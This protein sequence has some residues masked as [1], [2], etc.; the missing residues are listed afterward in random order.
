[1]KLN[2]TTIPTP[3]TAKISFFKVFESL[4]KLANDQDADLADYANKLLK[5]CENY[6]LLR[7]GFD[8]KKLLKKYKEPIGKILKLLFPDVLLTNEIKA[9]TAPFD[10]EPFYFSTRFDNIVKA[11]GKDFKFELTQMTAEMM[12]KFSC[13]TILAAHYQMPLDLSTPF[14]WDI[15]NKDT[16]I[17]R[18]YRMAFNADLLEISPTEKAIDITHE[19][20]VQLINNFDDLEL[21]KEKFPVG[22]WKMRGIGVVNLM[23]V[24][25]EQSLSDITSNLLIKTQ[26]TLDQIKSGIQRIF[27]NNDL[28]VGFISYDND[29]MMASNDKGEL[30]SLLLPNGESFTCHDNMCGGNYSHLIADKEALVVSDIALFNEQAQSNFSAALAAQNF[31]SYLIAPLVHEEQLLG[32]LELGSTNKHELNSAS[33]L[34]IKD[35]LPILAMAG[36][37][38]RTEAQN[39]REAIIQQECTTIHPSVKWRFEEEA[40]KYMIAQHSGGNPNFKD[41]VFKEVFPLYG[42]MDIKGSSTIRNEGV[43]LDLVKQIDG[44]EAVLKAAHLLTSMDVYEEL[45]YRI[46]GFKHGIQDG[47]SAGSEHKTLKFVEGEINPVFAHLRTKHEELHP[48]LDAYTELLDPDLHMV[49]EARKRFD[50]S[51]Y[52]TNHALAGFIDKKQ[53]QAQQVFPHYFERYKTDGVEYN[54]YIGESISKDKP[55]DE[56]YLRNIRI[57]QLISMCEMEREFRVLQKS[58]HTPLE[59]ASL[60]L[61]YSTPLA[62]HF[63][64][65]EKRF[66]V[67]GAYNARYEIVK[68]RIDKAH[69]KGTNDRLTVPNKIAIVYSSDQDAREYRTYISYLVK[70]GFIKANS[71]EE[72]DLE[73]LQGIT[74]LKALRI[75]MNYVEGQELVENLTLEEVLEEIEKG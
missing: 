61:V 15:P 37:R 20:Y 29:T 70:K 60:V 47:L 62:I 53:Q 36:S 2:D 26:D 65:D 44:I 51:V 3:I 39:E 69:I 55:F 45:M 54:M 66:D 57:W 52:R 8:D 11:A 56:I 34:K 13:A 46:D 14:K 4:E 23:D 22:S 24:T 48:A 68:K 74:G 50:S 5:E 71:T 10:F 30:T 12:Y 49:Y 67:E 58:L 7:E 40:N 28:K 38:F 75:E 63:R 21:W 9:V 19:D 41:I 16:G 72:L 33:V 59:V 25:F 73:D 32:F 27:G 31:Q 42:Q 43:V 64:M 6:P 35:V 17:T 18:T 1:M